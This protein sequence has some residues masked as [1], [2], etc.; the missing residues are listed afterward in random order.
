MLQL[1]LKF[2][3]VSKSRYQCLYLK[4]FLCQLLSNR[5]IFTPFVSIE[6]LRIQRERERE[7]ERE[8]LVAYILC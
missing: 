4:A 7:R 6:K 8:L 2:E 3:V 1:Q 5:A